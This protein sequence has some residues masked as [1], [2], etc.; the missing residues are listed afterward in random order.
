VQVG[1]FG[2]KTLAVSR[3][4]G[5]FLRGYK[6][7]SYDKEVDGDP[8][9]SGVSWIRLADGHSLNKDDASLTLERDVGDKWQAGDQIVVTTTDYLPGHSEQLTIDEVRGATIMFHPKLQ[10]P[11]NGV[12]FA[13]DNRLG[14]ASPAKGRLQLDPDLI[15]NGAETRAAVGLLPRSIRI[16]SAGDKAGETF[17]QASGRTSCPAGSPNAFGCY[18]FGAHTVVR[19][20]FAFYAVQG[21]E[22]SQL[23]QGGKIGHYPVHFHMARKTP[24][25]AYVK[26]SAVNESM[27]RW[28]VVHS[29][30][31]V[32]LARNVGYKSI[33]HG[34]YLEDGTET[35]NK[36]YS[37]LGVFARSATAD[38]QNPRRVP[39]ILVT[40]E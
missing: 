4:G 33:G 14:A 34:Y 37:N 10:W 9:S 38:D 31:G 18:Y 32:T 40:Q 29:T 1:Y 25:V 36:L 16:V 15:K 20:G 13:L 23:G 30:Q 5:L 19:Q 12:R 21:V 39:G 27:T 26:D 35:D 7:A 22:F 17:E 28:Y 6:G 24:S 11:H 8:L 2:Y 3:D